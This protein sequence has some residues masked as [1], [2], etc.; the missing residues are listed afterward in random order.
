[1]DREPFMPNRSH[2]LLVDDE[3]VALKFVSKI[4]SDKGLRFHGTR[5]PVE[6][7]AYLVAHR[8]TT[9]ITDLQM[10]DLDGLQLFRWGRERQPFLRGILFSAMLDYDTVLQVVEKGFDDCL[11]KP[12]DPEV[13]LEAVDRCEAAYQ[14]WVTR[15]GSFRR[16]AGT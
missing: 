4:L 9:L 3:P 5:S 10:P 14:R 8:V 7:K 2:I 16:P 11:P 13:L 6:A 1:M 12:V 15:I